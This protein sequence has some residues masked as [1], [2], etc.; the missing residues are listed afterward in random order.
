MKERS[1]SSPRDTVNILP[2]VQTLALFRHYAYTP[3]Q[4]LAEFVD[5]SISSW[6]RMQKELESV[7]G[8]GFK[9]TIKIDFDPAEGRLRIADNAGGI[10]TAE[11]GRAFTVGVVPADLTKMNQFGV[12]MKVAACWFADHWQVRTSALNEP[13][14]STVTFNMPDII[15]NSLENL[16]VD[17]VK[18]KPE[19]HMTEILL[20]DLHHVPQGR[21]LV[22]IG[23]HLTKMYRKFIA[24]GSVNIYW[25][26][27]K[28]AVEHPTV[29]TA[30]FYKN[31][32]GPPREWKLPLD[33]KLAGLRITGTALLFE[34]FKRTDCA[35]NL[36]WRGR[37][38]KG[39][40]EPHYRPSILFGASNTFRTGRL[41]IE[42]DMDA[43]RPTTDRAS[44]D[45]DANSCSEEQLLDEVRT[46][47]SK[48]ACPILAQGEWYRAQKKDPS[49]E[50]EVK[51]QL[52]LV[53][54]AIHDRGEKPMDKLA[55]TTS[56]VS[57]P[58]FLQSANNQGLEK[59]FTVAVS[60]EKWMVTIEFG[61]DPVDFEW[62]AISET[63]KANKRIGIKLGMAHPFN[64]QYLDDTTAA[65]ILRLAAALAFAE[66]AARNA[67]AKTPSLV[68]T[69]MDTFLR[70]VLSESE[71]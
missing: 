24:D 36:F 29:L 27:K 64:V 39:N 54:D 33:F 71:D 57:Y 37:L 28:L 18:A 17:Q 6:Q 10:G 21:T 7:E 5:N 31:P 63:D 9:L 16:P 65:V 59:T 13:V 62:V 12:G 32:A 46:Q 40:M 69:N 47:L 30:P 44:I 2:G 49:I 23:D 38:I 14:I 26:G 8:K 70:L 45:F 60:G 67:G 42:L 34:F 25:L 55:A 66:L 58:G 11:Y 56:G 35:L 22:K 53:G 41:Y 50:R 52:A 68:R 20:W 15:K 3:W 51:E 61:N 19:V 4:A 43:F 48:P 1:G